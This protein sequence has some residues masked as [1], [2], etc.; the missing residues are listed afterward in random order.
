MKKNKGKIRGI[1]GLLNEERV[2]GWAF[3][4]AAEEPIEL[5]L[6]LNGKVIATRKADIFRKGLK[7]KKIHPT[8]KC[9]YV[10]SLKEFELRPEDRLQVF[11]GEVRLPKSKV[12]QERENAKLP[13]LD[14]YYFF[15]H[16]PKTAGTSFRSMLY[17]QFSQEL[18]YPNMQDIR[19]N[20][21]LYPP[22]KRLLRLE[23]A[24]V[25]PKA[26]LTGHYPFAAGRIFPKVPRYMVF[27]RSP[28]ERVISNVY[29]IHRHD[30]RLRDLPI[31]QIVEKAPWQ[32]GNLQTRFFSDRYFNPKIKYF[33]GGILDKK[34]LAQAKEN[35]KKCDFIGLTEQFEDSIAIAEKVFGWNL[36]TRLKRNISPTKTVEFPDALRKRIIELNQLDLEFYEFGKTLFEKRKEQYL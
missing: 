16:L 31:E 33:P 4:T 24:E 21:G 18:I 22:Y 14:T 32:I 8:G 2:Q 9:G 3:R 5:Q 20:N 35:L 26:L 23:Q 1:I 17:E 27:L 10:F 15:I 6:Q 13:Q 7:E 25:N 34:A 19:D 12:I 36:G 28:I 11:C 30:K 29:H